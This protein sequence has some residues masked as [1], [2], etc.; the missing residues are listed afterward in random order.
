MLSPVLP[1]DWT[2]RMHTTPTRWRQFPAP[3]A[4]SSTTT[5]ARSYGSATPRS[6]PPPPRCSRLHRPSGRRWAAETGVQPDT[7]V[8]PR[9]GARRPRQPGRDRDPRWPRLVAGTVGELVGAAATVAVVLAVSA[10]D[11]Q[12][13]SPSADLTTS[14]APVADVPARTRLDGLPGQ[15]GSGNA[16]LAE[17]GSTRRLDVSI[18]RDDAPG[19]TEVW[20]FEPGTTRMVSLGVLDGGRAPSSFRLRWTLTA[21]SAWTCPRSVT[22]AARRTGPPAWRGGCSASPRDCCAPA[23][24]GRRPRVGRSRSPRRRTSPR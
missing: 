7:G 6:M 15:Q 19:F 8:Q 21:T 11:P 13:P 2:V 16:V 3:A 20:L 22:T 14:T 12:S 9:A 1:I 4:D 17:R 24:T 18:T 5:C 23:G 10:G